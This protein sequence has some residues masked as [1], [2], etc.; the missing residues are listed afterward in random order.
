MK[1]KEYINYNLEYYQT[2][3]LAD[4]LFM[5][6]KDKFLCS[7][8][9]LTLIQKDVKINELR[10]K[11]YKDVGKY[12]ISKIADTGPYNRRDGNKY[13]SNMNSVQG[14]LTGIGRI[15]D[16]D[17]DNIYLDCGLCIFD[18]QIIV[19]LYHKDSY[20]DS[21]I[22]MLNKGNKKLALVVVYLV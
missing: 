3:I 9:N 22:K 10:S 4:N 13:W 18:I 8:H 17:D 12:P 1:L 5:E 15:I 19:E 16:I 21:E 6:E 11:I 7:N 2:K 14:Y 20:S